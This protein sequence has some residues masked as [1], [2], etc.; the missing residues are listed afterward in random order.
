MESATESVRKAPKSRNF[1]VLYAFSVCQRCAHIWLRNRNIK[2]LSHSL[3]SSMN[4]VMLLKKTICL[5]IF[6]FNC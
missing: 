6:L 2:V 4:Y 3:Y 1:D 5:A